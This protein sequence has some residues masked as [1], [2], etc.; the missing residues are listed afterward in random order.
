MNIAVG[1]RVAI[2]CPVSKYHG[3]VG[4]V[5]QVEESSRYVMVDM[6]KGTEFRLEGIEV[7]KIL[8]QMKAANR[9]AT[10][11]RARWP[12]GDPQWFPVEWIVPA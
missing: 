11:K 6:P 5:F 10:K 8:Q 4:E 12:K 2:N 9:K 7:N 1:D 3:I